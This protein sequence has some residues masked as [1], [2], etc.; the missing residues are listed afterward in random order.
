MAY[1]EYSPG[2]PVTV[3]FEVSPFQGFPIYVVSLALACQNAVGAAILAFV[4]QAAANVVTVA[5]YVFTFAFFTSMYYFCLDHLFSTKINNHL[6]FT[7]TGKALSGGEKC[8]N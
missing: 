3:A 1:P 5:N 7:I 4:L 8:F 2:R 6:V